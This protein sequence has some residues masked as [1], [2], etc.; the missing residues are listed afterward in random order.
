MLSPRSSDQVSW[1]AV[2][3]AGKAFG[4]A[5][6]GIIGDYYYVFGGMNLPLAQAYNW[7]TDH[8]ELSTPPPFGSC[9]W[10]GV[11]TDE[12]I[13][14]I[15]RY[16]DYSF[17]DE[18]QKFTPVLNEPYGSWTTVADYPLALAGIAAAWDGDNYIYAGGGSDLNNIYPNAYRYDIASDEWTEIAPLPIAMTYHGGAFINGK[19]HVMG[20]IQEPSTAHYVYDPLTDSWASAAEMPIPNYFATFSLTQNE[21]HI[22]SVGGGGGYYV[23]PATNA[24]QFYDPITD[25]WFQETPLPITLGL[26]AATYAPDESLVSTGGFEEGFFYPY[27][28][29]GTGFSNG[30]AGLNNH[31]EAGESQPEGYAF[32][33]AYP[34][35]FNPEVHLSF[36]LPVSH[37]VKMVIVGMEGRVITQVAGG[38]YSAGTHEI[39]FQAGN[40]PSGVY[41]A[42]LE[43]GSFR[44]AQKI[45]F[46]K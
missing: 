7:S 37:Q 5:S 1:L 18:V 24:V 30:S 9:N 4:R 15:G 23:W 42:R 32:H 36:T 22:I 12:A 29:K 13:Y 39:P 34:N 31:K 6:G 16:C 21:T 28:F 19:F 43:A 44:S 27:T 17:G 2:A 38:N 10:C 8:W 41:I 25:L 33:P 20:G 35:P 46:L 3:N 26:N 11:A 14:L 40:L 45:L